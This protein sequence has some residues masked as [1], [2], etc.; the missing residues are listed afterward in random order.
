MFMAFDCLRLDKTDVRPQPLHARKQL[1]ERVLDRAPAVLL[2]VRR[3]SDDGLKAWQEVLEHGYEGMVAKDPASPYV[4]A[5]T[6]KWLE[7]QTAR[8]RDERAA[9]A[10]RAVFLPVSFRRLLPSRREVRPTMALE[11]RERST[12]GTGWALEV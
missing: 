4:G 3:L 10:V 1:L 7:G 12:L 5:R 9:H 11:Y 8:L 6:L 2:P